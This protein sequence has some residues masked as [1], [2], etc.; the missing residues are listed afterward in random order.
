MKVGTLGFF[1]L[2]WSCVAVCICLYAL[3]FVAQFKSHLTAQY[4]PS[5]S[6]E[7][8]N[9]Y[10]INTGTSVISALPPLLNEFETFLAIFAGFLVQLSG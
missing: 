8:Y 3:I 9:S 10:I 2:R 5:S 7:H 6:Q 1:E 4:R